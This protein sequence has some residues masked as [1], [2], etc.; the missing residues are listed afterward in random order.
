M[1]GNMALDIL[2][3]V[4]LFLCI[5]GARITKPLSSINSD[6]YLS[7]ATSKSYR[8][9]F[10]IVVI[11]HHLAQRTETGAF[12][13]NFTSMG[14]LAV[15]FF[16][17]LSGYGLQ[18]S[19]IIKFE[20]YKNDFLLKRIPTVLIPYVIITA[21][22]WLLHLFLGH[23]YTVKD[24]I[25]RFVIGEPIA[26]NS[27]FIINIFFFYIIFWL[28]MHI[29]KKHYFMMILG[30]LIWYFLYA[31]FCIEMQYG[32][33]WFVSSHLLVVGMLWATYEQNIVNL[34]K[35]KYVEIIL[36]FA[37][38]FIL[39][40]ALK[41]YIS[42]TNELFHILKIILSLCFKAFFVL[43]ALAFFMK[44]QI[45]NKILN[46]LGEISLEL[47]ISHG[48]FII[49]LRSNSIYINNELIWCISVL[50]GTILLSYGLHI[51]FQAILKAYK[52]KILQ[53]CSRETA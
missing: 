50:A 34:F 39:H 45:G 25:Y 47:Y 8:G 1:S 7:I 9:I 38:F 23:F 10:A 5:F 33:H 32:S 19:Y 42:S 43:S 27:W 35:R 46:F 3:L 52:R 15:A 44:I 53:D 40:Y 51:L 48:L 13:R 18:K 21:I 41:R 26:A 20:K 37:I 24:V 36:F 31:F 4:L 16:F 17:F 28:L 11:F 22:Y 29:C 14:A 49:L 2:P 12:F 6:G 30:G